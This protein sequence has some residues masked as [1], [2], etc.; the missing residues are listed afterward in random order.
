MKEERIIERAKQWVREYP[1]CFNMEETRG[2]DSFKGFVAGAKWLNE[3]LWHDMDEMPKVGDTIICVGHL[4]NG[5]VIGE[6]EML[7]GHI[8][9]HCLPK[10]NIAPKGTY[11][12]GWVSFGRCNFDKW[13][14][15]SEL[16]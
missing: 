2:K 9:L 12:R 8:S 5:Y 14:S 15:L 13:L 11:S 16:L 3:S 10:E 7:D 4:I 1:Q 6:A